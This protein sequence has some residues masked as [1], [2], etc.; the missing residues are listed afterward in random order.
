MILRIEV[1][2]HPAAA[3]EEDDNGTETIAGWVGCGLVDTDVDV[4]GDLCVV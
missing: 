1:S 3:V 2:C 4:A